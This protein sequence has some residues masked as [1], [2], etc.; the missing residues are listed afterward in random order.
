M[1]PAARLMGSLILSGAM[2]QAIPFGRRPLV[3]ASALLIIAGCSGGVVPPTSPTTA[4]SRAMLLAGDYSLTITLDDRCAGAMMSVWNYRAH[5]TNKN[6]FATV[7]VIG[8]GY[9]Q[10][11]D[12]GQVYTYPDFT[13]RF[14]WNFD[15]QDLNDPL[16]PTDALLLYGASPITSD[17]PIRNGTMAGTISGTAS[18]TL[19]LNGR[20]DGMHRFV[21]VST[22]N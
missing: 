10:S 8:N 6:G 15:Y 14:I 4:E 2:R 19:N 20:C 11:T 17:I 5:L 12:V 3:L 16:P 22:G 13:A 18:T 21:L 9:V 1:I 7:G